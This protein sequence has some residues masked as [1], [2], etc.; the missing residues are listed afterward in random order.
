MLA[1]T[2]APVTRA[3]AVPGPWPQFLRVHVQNRSATTRVIFDAS[4]AA[5]RW[6]SQ[7]G[8]SA[9]DYV[10]RVDH[11]GLVKSIDGKLA[12]TRQAIAAG[13]ALTVFVQFPGADG[14]DSF[15][16][17]PRDGG[18]AATATTFAGRA[19][20]SVQTT[21]PTN[22]PLASPL[23]FE[24]HVGVQCR[25]N[26]YLQV[27]P[28][29]TSKTW[30]TAPGT[31]AGTYRVR[32]NPDGSVTSLDGTVWTATNA[33]SFDLGHQLVA[34]YI[35]HACDP[36]GDGSD[37][38]GWDR[39]AND[40]TFRH[41]TT[42]DEG[43]DNGYGFQ[44]WGDLNTRPRAEFA[45]GNY[46]VA[47]QP[48]AVP[49]VDLVPTRLSAASGAALSVAASRQVFAATASANTAVLA[50]V[51][52]FADALAGIP[53]ATAKRGPL[54]LTPPNALD[55]DVGD[56]LARVLPSG[57]TVYL[58]GG[59]TALG[60]AVADAVTARG[61][62]P[63]RLSGVTR[64]ETAVAVAHEIGPAGIAMVVNAWNYPDALAA[65]AAAGSA[66]V[67][68]ILL[69]DVTDVP[70]ATAEQL[71]AGGYQHRIVFGGAAVVSDT[72]YQALD[73]TER[74]A[75]A[76]RVGTAAAAARRFDPH[77]TTVWV[78]AGNDYI[79]GL[80]GGALSAQRRGPLLLLAGATDD[81]LWAYLQDSQP[82]AAI[83]VGSVPDDS[84][85]AVFGHRA[86]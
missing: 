34:V 38:A 58:L 24:I 22:P 85:D 53:L 68:H 40:G 66:G 21:A 63:V 43:L 55:A 28:E 52:Q 23:D 20:N 30:R 56:E 74:V 83:A 80:I 33:P 16:F 75:G 35:I 4:W 11:D 51:D 79:G 73:G 82:T 14:A 57:S 78:A 86:S 47:V 54:L 69:T 37:V 65:G 32:L 41:M 31:P 59:T 84:L 29:W 44:P 81:G 7:P 9:G 2:A 15:T 60:T 36:D 1:T 50:R 61:L 76:T 67:T 25:S 64:I 10:V 71:R 17:D 6:A 26:Q 27:G 13:S 49:A 46:I 8:V 39:N 18:L 3:G 48:A 12:F 72:T 62:H 5:T 77:A 70:T 45:A 42:F 19:G